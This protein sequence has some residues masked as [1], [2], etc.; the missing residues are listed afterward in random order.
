LDLS[1]ILDFFDFPPLCSFVSFVVKGFSPI[2][3]HDP[4]LIVSA[5]A[6]YFPSRTY[7]ARDGLLPSF[8]PTLFQSARRFSVLIFSPFGFGSS[9]A[10]LT[11]SRRVLNAASTR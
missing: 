8:R 4:N 2:A 5:P 7:S 1:R 9:P 10:A 11:A 6:L 3:D